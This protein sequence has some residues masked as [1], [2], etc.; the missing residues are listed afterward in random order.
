MVF[1]PQANQ[2][3]A[4]VAL[5]NF[6]FDDLAPIPRKKATR[7]K[8][9][10]SPDSP[11]KWTAQRIADSYENITQRTRGALA[12][13]INVIRKKN[14]IAWEDMSHAADLWYEARWNGTRPSPN[15][16]SNFVDQVLGAPNH[17]V[18]KRPEQISYVGPNA[19]FKNKHYETLE[20]FLAKSNAK[21]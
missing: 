20:E 10:P 2:E 13:Q 12:I 15:A 19:R 16:L 17:R 8:A 9:T 6:D 4:S 1:S 5:M 7:K 14:P 21:G 11:D 3:A 18:T